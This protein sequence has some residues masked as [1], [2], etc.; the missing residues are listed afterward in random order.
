MTTFVRPFAFLVA[1][2]ALMSVS[3]AQQPQYSSAYL[4]AIDPT[5]AVMN[6]CGGKNGGMRAKLMLSAAVIQANPSPAVEPLLDGLGKVDFRITTADPLA[7]RYFNQ[8]L[9]FAYG[10]NHAAAIAAF[11]E[12]GVT[13]LQVMPVSDDPAATIR[14]LKEWV[15]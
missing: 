2:G 4:A 6:L 11:R 13:N 12:A 8:G 1:A 5:G 14:T 9:G 10:F 7:Q 3:P 15:S